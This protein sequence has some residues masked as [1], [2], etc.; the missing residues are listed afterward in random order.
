MELRQRRGSSTS[1]RSFKVN[2][3]HLA[4]GKIVKLDWSVCVIPRP[5]LFPSALFQADNPSSFL[6]SLPPD[7]FFTFQG[8]YTILSTVLIILWFPLLF[9][10]LKVLILKLS[11]DHFILFK[12]SLLMAGFCSLLF[13]LEFSA[14]YRTDFD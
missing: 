7:Y 10:S 8:K 13:H 6:H 5:Q 9:Q 2:H 11:K 12:S 4:P 1:F 14:T 3:F